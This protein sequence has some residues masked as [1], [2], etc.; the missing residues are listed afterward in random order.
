CQWCR[1][2]RLP[3]EGEQCFPDPR[4]AT[5]ATATPR[6]RGLRHHRPV[7]GGGG[8]LLRPVGGL[9]ATGRRSGDAGDPGRGGH[10]LVRGRG[11]DAGRPRRNHTGLLGSG[12]ITPRGPPGADDVPPRS[13]LRRGLVPGGIAGPEDRL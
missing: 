3:W 13:D 7:V 11:P 4:R 8:G 5:A 1:T 12:R 2:W 10:S 6:T 9:W